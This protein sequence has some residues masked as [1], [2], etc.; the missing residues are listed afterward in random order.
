MCVCICFPTT[1]LLPTIIHRVFFCLLD[2]LLIN[3]I[4]ACACV[5]VWLLIPIPVLSNRNA[6]VL[7]QIHIR[8]ECTMRNLCVCVYVC[9]YVCAYMQVTGI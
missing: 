7:V 4:N 9:V 8:S 2:L 3:I 6:L 1:Y 5:C